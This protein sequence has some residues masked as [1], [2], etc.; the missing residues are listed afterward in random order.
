M[1][2]C[3]VFPLL[4]SPFFSFPLNCITLRYLF[5][6]LHKKDLYDPTCLYHDVTYIWP[7]MI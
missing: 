6:L 4:P 7:G 2:L 3:I 1:P 5:A